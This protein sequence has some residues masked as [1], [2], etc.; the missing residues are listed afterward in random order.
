MDG[1]WW[2]WMEVARVVLDG[3]RLTCPSRSV[4]RLPPASSLDA[5]DLLCLGSF[6][7][8]F[9]L[10]LSL[11]FMFRL[12]CLIPQLIPHTRRR[13]PVLSLPFFSSTPVNA[14]PLHGALRRHRARR[15]A[16]T[17]RATT[18]TPSQLANINIGPN[19]LLAAAS[20]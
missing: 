6:V 17:I 10:F 11:F 2:L 9:F 4:G 7:F 20:S 14:I 1:G 12:Y 15:Q 18:A 16:C 8:S 3:P 19:V 13:D 5:D